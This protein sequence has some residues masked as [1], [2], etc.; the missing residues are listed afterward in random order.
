MAI[1]A[2]C[3]GKFTPLPAPWYR[4]TRERLDNLRIVLTGSETFKTPEG[5]AQLMAAYDEHSD[6]ASDVR[7]LIFYVLEGLI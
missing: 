2:R 6:A 4:K 5:R 7:T 3:G 1:F